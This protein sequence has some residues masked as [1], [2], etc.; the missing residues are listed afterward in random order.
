MLRSVRPLTQ[1]GKALTCRF[2]ELHGSII[3]LAMDTFQELD[4]S[5]RNAL[6]PVLQGIVSSAGDS[7]V[8]Y[9]DLKMVLAEKYEYKSDTDSISSSTIPLVKHPV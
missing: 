1:T 8:D 5:S 4:G 6:E 2:S 9:N 7:T 3:N